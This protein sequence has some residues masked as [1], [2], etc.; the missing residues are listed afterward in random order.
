MLYKE[1]SQTYW[2]L[3]IQSHTVN[4]YFLLYLSTCIYYIYIYIYTHCLIL[5]MLAGGKT[6]RVVVLLFE[7]GGWVGWG[8]ILTFMYHA[9][10]RGCYAAATSLV[11]GWV[12]WWWDINVHIPC[13]QTWMLRCCYVTGQGLGGVRWVGILTF[14][15]HAYRRGCYAAATSTGQGLGGVGWDINV[16]VPCVQTW[17]LRCCY[18][19]GQGLGGGVGWD[20]NVNVPCVHN[21]LHEACNHSKLQSMECG[22]FPKV[23]CHPLGA[24]VK[25]VLWTLNCF[26]E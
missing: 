6:A 7:Y 20:I 8:G 5:F 16:H 4:V 26:K 24:H 10:R 3:N 2:H 15:Y 14:M 9:Y 25:M 11:R 12:G 19:T 17:M 1:V 23:Q 18:V 22:K 13:V 21:L